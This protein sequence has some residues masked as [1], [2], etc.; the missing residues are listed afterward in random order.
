VF[1]VYNVYNRR[2]PFSIYFEQD[3][4]RAP[5]NQ[6]VTTEAIRFSVVGNFVPAVSYNFKF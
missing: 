5:A 3:L 2:N 6:P 1:S 4:N